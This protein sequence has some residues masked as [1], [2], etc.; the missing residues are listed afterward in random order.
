MATFRVQLAERPTLAMNLL[1]DSPQTWGDLRDAGI[2]S[3]DMNLLW[4][5]GVVR[6]DGAREGQRLWSLTEDGR[7][8]LRPVEDP[9]A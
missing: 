2:T 8:S 9:D 6:H 5:M 3:G 4:G 1:A 7:R